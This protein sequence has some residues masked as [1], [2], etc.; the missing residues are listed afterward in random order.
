MDF[1]SYVFELLLMKGSN[2]NS[3]SQL[4]AKLKHESIEFGQKIDYAKGILQDLNV[5]KSN[6]AL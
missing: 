2:F 1:T 6:G 4:F 3:V 5:L